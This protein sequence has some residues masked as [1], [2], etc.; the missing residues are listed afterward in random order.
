MCIILCDMDKWNVMY[1]ACS[2]LSVTICNLSVAISL[3]PG[4]AGGEGADHQ[5][6]VQ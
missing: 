5:D 2:L 6:V 3:S 4:D 1:N